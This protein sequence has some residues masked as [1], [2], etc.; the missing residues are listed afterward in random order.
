MQNFLNK[1]VLLCV[2]GG[3]AAY[4]SA[5]IIRLFKKEAADVRVVMTESAKEFI[6]PLT[7]QAVSGNEIH[8]SLLDIKAESAMG[9]IELAKWADIILIAPCTAESMSKI[10]HGRADDLMGALILA[11]SAETYIAPAMNMNMWLDKTT[12][13]NYKALSSRG[14]SFIGPANGEQACGDIGPGRME[15]PI[16]IIELIHTSLNKGPLLGKTI[17]ITA[18]P[19]REQID[20]VRFISNNSSGKMGYALALAAIEA[21][22]SV[23]LISGPVAIS[24]HKDI[25]LYKVNSA[26]EMLERCIKCMK[27]TDIFISCAA[28]ADYKPAVVSETKIKKDES[29][30]L[31]IHL[32]K[33]KDILGVISSKYPSV[34]H[35]GFAA[36]TNDVDINAK[37][38][39][40]SKKIDMIIS[41]D[42]SN[43][44]IGFD[45]DENEVNVITK[46]DS[47]FLKKDKKIRIAREI[48]NIVSTKINKI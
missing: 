46:T 31:K 45:V 13:E 5:E 30:H 22:A 47:I 23:N 16:R 40:L 41:N 21:G 32:E 26:D 37:A 14:L 29:D 7:L 15:E 38:K 20:P 9:H 10:A 25:N 4:K 24:A 3:I 2:T 28:V 43:K 19:T 18:G 36:E 34:F 35:I 11:S 48:L 27:T 33:N 42:V 6:T 39:L 8:D 17:T 1:N 12:Q 44:L